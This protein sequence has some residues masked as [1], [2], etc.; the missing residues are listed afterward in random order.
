M[1][2][3]NTVTPLY[4]QIRDRLREELREGVFS[5]GERVPSEAELGARYGVSRITAKQAI[6][7]LVQEG[8]L[9]RQQGKGTFV[10]RPRVPH[11]L[12]RITSF[13]QQIV[14]RGM[15]PATRLL[16]AE[17]VSAR[18][19][20][21]E[22]LAVPEGTLVTKLRRLRLA[23]GE[24][25]G[26]QTAYVPVELCPG[27]IDAIADDISLYRL[28]KEK[29]RTMPIRAL[30]NYTAIVLGTHDGR[31]LNVPEGSPALSV[32]RISYL[33]D[34]RAL[35]Y[36]VSILRADRYTLHVVLQGEAVTES[37]HEGS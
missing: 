35:E 21:R 18:G 13:S 11:N 26:V 3:R 36:V 9:Y 34:N 15:K 19:R 1:L 25:M 5:P 10:S 4:H 28:F 22:A 14:D 6:Q 16:E 7:A 17:I 24:I 12:N 32:E 20:T 37:I 2:E 30:E 8:L 29:Y 23:D 27:L 33:A 31:L